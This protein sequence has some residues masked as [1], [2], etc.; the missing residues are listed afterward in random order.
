LPAS[1]VTQTSEAAQRYARALFELAQDKGAL[2]VVHKDFRAFAESVRTSKDLTTLLDSP[3]FGRDTKVKALGGVA[4]KA[5]YSPIFSN[6]LGVMATNGRAKD[7]LSAEY[8]FDQLYANQRGIKRAVV[9]TAKE[10]SGAER[11]RIESLL[12]KL[13]GGE[14]ELSSEVDPS[15]IGG[16]QLRIGSKLVD[17]SVAAKL[18]RMN[19]AMKGAQ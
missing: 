18:N 17:A 13:V 12:A 9:R 7:I 5:G 15:L 10:M 8:A 4:K 6:F 19:T 14:V 1:S 11:A 3:A 16:I 2:A